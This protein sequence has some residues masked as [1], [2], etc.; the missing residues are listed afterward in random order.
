M[1]AAR[2]RVSRRRQIKRPQMYARGGQKNER[3]PP[4]EVW[5][6]SFV[7]YKIFTCHANRRAKELLAAREKEGAVTSLEARAR[8][9]RSSRLKSRDVFPHLKVVTDSQESVFVVRRIE[10]KLDFTL[11]KHLI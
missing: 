2:K 7:L 10:M 11:S 4:G 5:V 9:L 8:R 3:A 1:P 6:V